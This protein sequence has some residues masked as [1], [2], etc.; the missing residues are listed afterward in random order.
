MVL[1]IL[2]QIYGIFLPFSRKPLLIS[3]L[4]SAIA[5]ILFFI[6][7]FTP[8][9]GTITLVAVGIVL[10]YVLR[11]LGIMIFK[12]IEIL[13]KKRN[14]MQ[15]NSAPVG[16]A[17]CSGTDSP[18]EEKDNQSDDEENTQGYERSRTMDSSVTA[19]SEEA[20][21]RGIR[22]CNE[23]VTKQFRIPGQQAARYFPW[24]QAGLYFAPYSH[25]H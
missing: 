18:R 1:V 21:L 15:K 19:I 10:D 12:T 8:F 16:A 3:S 14:K 25:K 13:G 4:N 22:Q 5:A 2:N 9:E 11:I 20:P 17:Q 24:L 7:I 23:A 6:A